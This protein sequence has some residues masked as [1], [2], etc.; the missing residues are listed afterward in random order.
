M[1]TRKKI[2]KWTIQES[3]RW[4]KQ[5]QHCRITLHVLSAG[6]SF[7]WSPSL[8]LF[9]SPTLS[10]R[11]FFRSDDKTLLCSTHFSFAFFWEYKRKGNYVS[12]RQK[13][14]TEKMLCV[15]TQESAKGKAHQSEE[16]SWFLFW[17]ERGVLCVDEQHDVLVSLPPFFV[18]FESHARLWNVSTSLDA[19]SVD[20]GVSV[21]VSASLSIRQAGSFIFPSKTNKA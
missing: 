4:E 19:W 6:W 1:L 11:T 20:W 13:N 3:T 16:K 2:H 21:D 17:R 9:A 14:G 8:W 15:R 18:L 7:L 12:E 5:V 10:F